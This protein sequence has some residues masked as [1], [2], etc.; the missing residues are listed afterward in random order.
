[1]KILFVHPHGSNWLSGMKDIST[2][3]NL[4][5]PLGM[6]SIIAVLERAGIDVEIIDC[7]ATPMPPAEL[8][9][10]IIRRRRQGGS[11]RGA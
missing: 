7:Y 6:L 2:V 9:L 3:F 10:E 8:V 1:V 11:L 5:P 4:M